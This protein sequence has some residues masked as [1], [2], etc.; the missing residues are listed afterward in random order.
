MLGDKQFEQGLGLLHEVI[1]HWFIFQLPGERARDVLDM[2]LTL[3]DHVNLVSQFE[4]GKQAYQVAL[5][6]ARSEDRV[7]V[8]GSFHVLD[9][10]FK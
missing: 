4:S 7:I 1:D 10:V 5:R 8:F 2:K 9:E 3:C 6:S